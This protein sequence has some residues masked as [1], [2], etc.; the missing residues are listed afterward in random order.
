MNDKELL[1]DAFGRSL[2]E[3]V[4]N[5]TIRL[6]KRLFHE[7]RNPLR[8]NE[9]LGPIVEGLEGVDKAILLKLIEHVAALNTHAFLNFIEDGVCASTDVTF[10]LVMKYPDGTRSPLLDICDDPGGELVVD[11]GWF[12]QHLDEL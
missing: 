12:D 2:V 6:Y 7:P 3:D 5:C 11:G 4:T 8:S 1:A 10:E 9:Q